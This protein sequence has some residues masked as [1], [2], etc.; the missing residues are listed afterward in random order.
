MPQLLDLPTEILELII[1]YA[2]LETP[3][4]PGYFENMDAEEK[5]FA[6]T[7]RLGLICH[8][9]R[10]VVIRH[11]YAECRINFFKEREVFESEVMMPDTPRLNQYY[12]EVYLSTPTDDPPSGSQRLDL[13][14]KWRIKVN[15]DAYK[16]YGHF[17]K[18]L[19][20][21]DRVAPWKGVSKPS[22]PQE[23]VLNLLNPILS[24]FSNLTRIGFK[25]EESQPRISVGNFLDGVAA[26]LSTCLSLKHIHFMI[27]KD[28]MG[29]VSKES[30]MRFLEHYGPVSLGPYAELDSI[31]LHLSFETGWHLPMCMFLGLG[32]VLEHS[33]QSLKK[34]RVACF[35]YSNGNSWEDF[36]L[37]RED[38]TKQTRKFWKLP[39]LESLESLDCGFP[40]SFFR[41]HF[42]DNMKRVQELDAGY[43]RGSKSMEVGEICRVFPNVKVLKF[44]LPRIEEPLTI[45]DD[46]R[47]HKTDDMALKELHL[48]NCG[49]DST[50]KI[51]EKY[52]VDNKGQILGNSKGRLVVIFTI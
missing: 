6:R 47:N 28:F 1:D 14:K 38:L 8:T 3:A 20:V 22:R 27:T 34:M 9:F 50:H 35:A 13:K 40:L 21:D 31:S 51:L 41:E 48:I 46:I 10:K 52:G 39:A 16:H 37:N 4:K 11:I 5:S 30:L 42:G 33:M 44:R 32:K 15:P 19:E 23:R 18:S 17:V 25:Y 24:N 43:P 29:E 36:R 12:A 7:L 2:R 26:A 45:L 49:G